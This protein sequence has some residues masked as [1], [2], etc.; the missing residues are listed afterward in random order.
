MNLFEFGKKKVEVIE[1]EQEELVLLS[2]GEKI[3]LSDTMEESVLPL[4]DTIESE[5]DE[6]NVSVQPRKKVEISIIQDLISNEYSLLKDEDILNECKRDG[7]FLVTS[8][9]VICTSNLGNGEINN[10]IDRVKYLAE[11]SDKTVTMRIAA[12]GAIEAVLSQPNSSLLI[13][14]L[15]E[16]FAFS[17]ASSNEQGRQ[18]LD[19][20]LHEARIREV[21]DIHIFATATATIVKN[22]TSI[23]ISNHY[24]ASREPEMGMRLGGVIFS[25]LASE[26]SNG[27]FMASEA[28]DS[29]FSW[30]VDNKIRR[31]RASTVPIKGGCKIVLRS[32][33]PFSA[34]I[35]KLSDLGFLP[36]QIGI[37]MKLASLPFGS[38]LITGQTGSGKT[39][40]LMSLLNL[41][42]ET[43]SAHALEDPVE[44][45]L[46]KVAQTEINLTGDVDDFGVNVGSFAD[47]GKR[48][49][50][51][52]IDVVM[53]G[54]IRDKPTIDVF[55]RLASTGHL[56]MGTMH[57][58]SA[59]GVPNVMVEYF[60]LSP[61]QV[62]DPDAFTAFMHQ[63]LANK[64]CTKCSCDHKEHKNVAELQLVNALEKGEPTEIFVMQ[65]KMNEILTA[66]KLFTSEELLEIRYKNPKGCSACHHK[67]LSGKTVLAEILMLDAEI[68]AH[69]EKRDNVAMRNYLTE[70]KYPRVRDHALYCIRNGIIDTHEA[71]RVVGDLDNENAIS[72]NYSDLN[73]ELGKGTN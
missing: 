2:D 21:A 6:P 26:G 24:A 48:L 5:I 35:P 65:T 62:A 1:E 11:E 46:P 28:N 53:F 70:V 47:Y 38:L 45:L 41:Q 3:S 44:W 39:T 63:K 52:D 30:K 58:S 64:L 50:R 71:T 10:I 68:R 59:E 72:F 13:D 51:Q 25:I 14:E 8:Q 22:R 34:E 19:T 9:F 73:V 7:T 16:S 40:T 17:D 55:Y 15:D 57:V 69:I 49:L 31:Y 36:S 12:Q 60:G 4:K 18:E 37:L 29:T 33:D 42:P 43:R 27:T 66:E 20:L 54:E 67:G 32:L 61:L 23:G 56:A